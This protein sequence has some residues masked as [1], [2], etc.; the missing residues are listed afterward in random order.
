[1]KPSRVALLLFLLLATLPIK[2]QRI[3]RLPDYY[4]DDTANKNP[5]FTFVRMK[6]GSYGWEGWTTDYPKADYQF[7]RGLRGWAKS[8]LAINNEP[9]A[10]GLHDPELFNYPFMYVV[11]PG[12]MVLNDQDAAALREYLLRGGFIMLDDFWGTYE[13]QNVQDQLKKVF[14]EYPIKELPLDH[15]LFHCYFDVNE[16]VQVPQNMN[17]IRRGR[18][19]EQDGYVPHYE[20]ITDNEGRVLVL[21]A[22]NTDNGDAWEWIDDP[23]YPLRF[24]LAAY[25]LGMNAI[26]YSMTH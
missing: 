21:I 6:Y 17:W 25:R 10:V 15:P 16:V 19:Y 7:I 4:P 23:R 5:E 3:S 1:M 24:G 11:E 14:P 22:R 2:S 12:H 8:F 26:V 9:N 20:G 18:T 13:W